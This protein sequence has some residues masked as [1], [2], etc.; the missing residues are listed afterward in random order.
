VKK[1]LIKSLIVAAL[2]VAVITGG[3]FGY[4]KFFGT[5]KAVAASSRYISATASKMDLSVNIQGTGSAFAGT[6]KEVTPS[7]EGVIQNLNV[8]V[9]DTVNKGDTLFVAYSEDIANALET[10]KNNVSKQETAITTSNNQRAS[11]I[12]EAQTAVKNAQSQLDS[13][14]KALQANPTD[15]LLKAKVQT[16]QDNLDKQKQTLESAQNSSTA[17]TTQLTNAQEQYEKALAN[18]NKMTVTSPISG[19]VVAKTYNT[20]DDVQAAKSVL[21]IIDPN[22]IKVKV[23]VDELDIAKVTSGQ[24]ATVKFDAI[25]DKSFEGTVEAIAQLG[26]SNNNVTTYDVTLGIKEPTAIKVGMNAN[27]T[28]AIQSK[29]D[30][31]VVPVEAVTKESDKKYVTV[32]SSSG[33]SEGAQSRGQRVEV[34]T[35]LENESYV[36]IVSGVTEGEKLLVTLPTTTT[37]TNANRSER[38]GFGGASMGGSMGGSLGGGSMNSGRTSSGGQRP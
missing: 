16:A 21:T 1:K 5:N 24:T 37:S 15:E 8:Q 6:S 35:G 29:K 18:Y 10:A 25:S 38:S 28:I 31:L 30:A 26:T 34:T 23:A 33:E 27:I 11:K 17:D 19:V 13:A 22:S 14:N 7:N 12:S 20:G 32:S 3:I 4:K 9:G 36:E 2:A